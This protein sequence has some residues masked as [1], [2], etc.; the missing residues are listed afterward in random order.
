M[1]LRLCGV[2]LACADI[3]DPA[4]EYA[5]FE[6]NASPGMANYAASGDEERARV[7]LLIKVMFES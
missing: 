4:A 3:S 7:K 5:I 1:G 2:D 6:I